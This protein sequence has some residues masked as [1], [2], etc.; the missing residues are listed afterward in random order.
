MR[1]L[2]IGLAVLALLLGVLLAWANA[3]PAP[4]PP[5][6]H[7]DRLVVIK[8][9]HRLLLQQQG[10]TLASFEVALGRGGKGPKRREGDG[11]TPEGLYTI[12]FHNGSSAFYRALHISYP[13]RA[14]LARARA[15]GA[16]A[17]GAVMVHGL[18]PRL[19][20]VGRLQRAV[21]WTNGCVALSDPEM[22]QVYALVRDGT[23]IEIRP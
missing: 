21:D 1:R 4:L 16:P 6:A 23:P 2:L 17:G 5:G 20:W 3:A 14:D 9:E 13:G 11:R 8:G 22:Q 7:V 15:A 12:D 10:Q 19:A 18:P